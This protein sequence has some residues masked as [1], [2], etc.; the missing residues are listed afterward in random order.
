L[1]CVQVLLERHYAFGLLVHG[2]WEDASKILVNV[3]FDHEGV[4][5]VV[6]GVTNADSVPHVESKLLKTG[7]VVWCD[8]SHGACQSAS[9]DSVGFVWLLQ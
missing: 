7:H 3:S 8:M 2:L 4:E 1:F 6:H 9:L 5:R